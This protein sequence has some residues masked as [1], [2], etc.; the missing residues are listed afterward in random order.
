[1]PRGVCAARRA[2]SKIVSISPRASAAGERRSARLAD[3]S[4]SQLEYFVAVADEQHVGRAARRLHV[5]QPA[6]SRQ[7]RLLEEELEVSLF[8]RTPQG[9]RLSPAG[10]LF[11]AHARG[12]L[13]GVR[14]AKD[15]MRGTTRG[16]R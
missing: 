3:V 15:A 7:I 10:A 13:Q 9:M 4:L 14:E 2:A 8:R 12:I 5:A 11:R 1:M 16:D 6:V